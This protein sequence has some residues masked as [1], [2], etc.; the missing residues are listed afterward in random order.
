MNGEKKAGKSGILMILL[1]LLLIIVFG[2]IYLIPKMET[3]NKLKNEHKVLSQEIN[4]AKEDSRRYEELRVLN[5]RLQK[6]MEF[7]KTLLPKETE[8][9]DVLKK[10]SE[11]GL[12]KGLVVTMWKPQSK[13]VHQSTEVYEIPVEVA[14][15]GRY[16]IFGGFFAETTKIERI[17]NIKKMEIKSGEKD[18]VMLTAT[19]TAVTYSLIPEEEK[20]KIQ[21]Q[22][23]SQEKKK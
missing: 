7:L 11:I 6:R 1:P 12:Q 10:L 2:S 13:T 18:P 17:L 20:K 8:V 16:H 21:E 15:K 14:M 5:E 9:S 4:K 19:M 3:L 23:K 22:K